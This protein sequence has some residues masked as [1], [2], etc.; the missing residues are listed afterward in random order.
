MKKLTLD[1]VSKEFEKRGYILL[2][3]K[4]KNNHKKLQALC[5]RK[6][7]IELLYNH[8]QQGIGCSVC[9]GNNKK[10]IEEVRKEFEKREY[11]LL[12]K[13]YKN[14]QQKLKILCP[15]KHN[16]EI[17]Y[18]SFQ[19]GIGCSVCS[20][21]NKKTI[22]EVKKEFEKRG[23]ILLSKEYKNNHKKLKI[24]CPREH[25]IEISYTNF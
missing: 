21:N 4:Y 15:N 5:P 2:S 8:F 22:E 9:S 14:N 7:R 3:K 12:S 18:Q 23:Y 1:F 16:I 6:H 20:G 17:I 13:E 25:R 10:T 19:Q 24:L 11:I